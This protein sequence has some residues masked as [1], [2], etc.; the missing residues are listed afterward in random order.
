M[1]RVISNPKNV[2]SFVAGES[3]ADA[4]YRIMEIGSG[5][6]EVVMNDTA[7]AEGAHPV[8]VLLNDPASGEEASVATAGIVRLEMAANC[9]R[10]ERIMPTTNG[11]GTPADADQKATAGIALSSNSEGDGGF[12]SLLISIAP[13]QANE[14]N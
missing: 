3:L 13:A 9:D 6:L 10:G 1:S 5:D 14:S 11:K 12:I 8:G 2:M 4:Q 7:A